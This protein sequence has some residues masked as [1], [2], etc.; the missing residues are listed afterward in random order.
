MAILKFSINVKTL[1]ETEQKHLK[2]TR[3]DDSGNELSVNPMDYS[4]QEITDKINKGE[5]KLQL[6]ESIINSTVVD[7]EFEIDYNEQ[8]F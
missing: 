7:K 4:P 6:V 5:F 2:A 1:L 8:A 3:L